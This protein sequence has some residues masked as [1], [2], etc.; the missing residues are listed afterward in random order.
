MILPRIHEDPDVHH[1]YVNPEKELNAGLWSL[2]AGATAFL[3]LRI[4]IK[5]TRRHGLWWDDHILLI[6]WLVLT[7]NNAI[8]T[9]EYATGYVTD[10]WDD[11]MH[12]LINITSCGTVIGQALTK[13]AFAVTLLKL[14][15]GYQQWGLWFCMGTMNLWMIFRCIFQWA[16]VCGKSSYDVWYRLN[17]CLNW[18]FRD[19]FKE[20]GNV[21]NIIMDFVFA[22]FPWFIT[23]NLDMRKGEK[24][25]LC[26]TMS[27]GMIVAVVS[28]VRTGWKDEGNQKDAYYFERNAHSNVWYSS[29]VVGTIIVQCIPIMRPL[30]RDIHTTLTSKK[31]TSESEEL[32]LNRLAVRAS[33]Q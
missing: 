22:V 29:E 9:V 23:W 26:L 18:T 10:T 17:F 8:I 16:K 4:W 33:K 11:R 30:L 24:I 19:N 13:T 12:I 7:A 3:A 28:A 2:Y 25:G 5:V 14:T 15:K 20:G 31:L 32:A 6:S 21:Y 27:L 1:D